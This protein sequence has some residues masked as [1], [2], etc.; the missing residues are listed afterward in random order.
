MPN[1]RNRNQ[2]F[3]LLDFE[4]CRYTLGIS[5]A[6]GKRECALFE[7]FIAQQ[8]RIRQRR[9]S[10]GEFSIVRSWYLTNIAASRARARAGVISSESQR[11]ITRCA[12]VHTGRVMSV[13]RSTKVSKRY[14]NNNNNFCNSV[15]ARA[16]DDETKS[17]GS[18]RS[19]LPRRSQPPGLRR[20]N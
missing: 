1:A 6:I 10:S 16:H 14:G 15:A 12:K 3:A 5:R 13:A 2:I 19:L 20:V 4:M 7:S 9:K 11:R 8:L 18:A 17:S